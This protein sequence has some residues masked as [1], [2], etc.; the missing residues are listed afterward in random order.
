MNDLLK[1]LSEEELQ[2]LIERYYSN[3]KVS[4]L[5]EEFELDI[6]A[7]ELI[8][9]FP[10]KEL[11]DVQ[12]PYCN[13]AMK[14]RYPARG[15]ARYS[16]PS[17]Y[18]G[19][20]AHKLQSPCGCDKCDEFAREEEKQRLISFREKISKT[21]F[22][23]KCNIQIDGLTLMQ[24]M[25]LVTLSLIS[26]DENDS[27]IS[28]IASHHLRLAPTE[29]MTLDIIKSLHKDHFI[30]IAEETSFHFME[31]GELGNID[32]LIWEDIEWRYNLVNDESSNA[33]FLRELEITIRDK[34]LWPLSWEDDLTKVWKE[35]AYQHCCKYLQVHVEEHGFLFKAGEKTRK[36]IN[37]TLDNYSILKSYYFLWVAVRN[38]ASYCLRK[39][40]SQSQAGY[41]IPGNIERRVDKALAS[42]DWEVKEYRKDSRC[43]KSA[44]TDY[45]AN[46]VTNLGE[47]F[48]TE[49]PSVDKCS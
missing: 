11:P 36:V 29:I 15:I 7:T 43:G 4:V 18:C 12:C 13:I 48:Y 6:N 16:W 42:N 40:L 27:L 31:F 3:E 9:N 20:C 22:V 23:R 14:Q 1:K 46:V 26:R 25:A 41:I 24:A 5:L 8:R 19:N 49:K 37:H 2:G 32:Q 33:E 45:F 30:E 38:V 44:M 10:L 39:N 35:L 17:P 28:S 47:D 34:T 21:T